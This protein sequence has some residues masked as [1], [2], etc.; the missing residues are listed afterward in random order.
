MVETQSSAIAALQGEQYIS[1]TTYRKNGTEKA[2][3][4]WFVAQNGKLYITT[5]ADSYK[6]KRIRHNDQV[7]FAA[8]DVRGTLKNGA[9]TFTGTA[10]LHTADTHIAKSADQ[11]LTQKYGLMYRGIR[12]MGRLRNTNYIFIEVTPQ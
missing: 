4:V 7:K 9:E 12:F 6:I 8:C 10:T 1:L 5:Q 2:T 3:P 11:W